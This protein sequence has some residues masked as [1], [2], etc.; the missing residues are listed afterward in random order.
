MN[1]NHKHIQS[2]VDRI[3]AN[4][5]EDVNV[6]GLADAFNMSPWHFQRTFKSLVG[7][8]L[9][10]YIR[11]RRLT[12][13]AELLL[14]SDQSI[15]DIALNVGFNSHEAFTRSF[16]SYFHH[17]PK[18]YRKNRPA[19]YLEEKPLLTTE[20]YEHLAKGMEQKPVIE[21][22]PQRYLVGFGAGIPSPFVSNEDYCDILYEPWI[23]LLE[24]ESKLPYRISGQY[25]GLMVSPS[26]NFTEGTLTYIAA[27]AVTTPTDVSDDMVL[28]AFP[29]QK[30]AMFEVFAGTENTLA[31]TIDY[32]YGYWLPNSGFTRGYG[33]DYELFENVSDF[34]D[35]N[36][37]SKYA[38]PIVPKG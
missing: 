20:L 6:V 33:N 25:Y 11:G 5:A 26:G 32:I 31:R 7:D 9:G 36:L 10:G 35:P 23:T 34:T 30:V 16:K 38:L 17:S 24:R 22:L 18:E 14:N 37:R 1:V 29:Q 4:L 12:R 21:E 28:F 13:A 8:T 27:A 19:V 2:L 3:E 15:I